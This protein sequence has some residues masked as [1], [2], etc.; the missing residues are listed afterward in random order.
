MRDKIYK[1]SDPVF[2]EKNINDLTSK[3]RNNSYPVRLIKQF[4]YGKPFIRS[5]PINTMP[6]EPVVFYKL[7]F[8]D[9][10]SH[11]LMKSLT[12]D[13]PL[14]AFYY[15]TTIRHLNFI[16]EERTPKDLMSDIIY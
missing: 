2:H 1:F 9:G 12:K 13:Q 15:T 11:S 7:P 4:L 3:F 16:I 8:I 6:Y 5:Q 14:I 10:L